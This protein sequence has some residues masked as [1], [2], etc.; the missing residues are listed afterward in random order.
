MAVPSNTAWNVKAKTTKKSLS[1]LLENWSSSQDSLLF[2]VTTVA[3]L[4]VTGPGSVTGT[5]SIATVDKLCFASVNDYLSEPQ[6]II[7]S[8][9]SCDSLKTKLN[10]FII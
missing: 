10:T 3:V 9:R 2:T 6:G 8:F 4:T 5:P 1:E 7:F